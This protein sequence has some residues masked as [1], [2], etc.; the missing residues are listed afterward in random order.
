[1]EDT[2]DSFLQRD[3]CTAVY[4]Y[5]IDESIYCTCNAKPLSKKK[6]GQIFEPTPVRFYH[7]NSVQYNN[8][9]LQTFFNCEMNSI[10]QLN[11]TFLCN[12]TFPMDLPPKLSKYQMKFPRYNTYKTGT[13]ETRMMKQ[14]RISTQTPQKDK[15]LI[16]I[17]P[18]QNKPPPL[19]KAQAKANYT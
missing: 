17:D 2:K 5:D 11:K 6:K 10:H 4:T 15:P 16:T 19:E 3:Q 14:K 9:T 12:Y 13:M 8:D 7:G 18:T 1:M